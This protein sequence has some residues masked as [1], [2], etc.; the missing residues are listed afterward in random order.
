ME[1]G[2]HVPGKALVVADA[3]SRCNILPTACSDES[4]VEEIESSVVE[5]TRT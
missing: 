2:E 4:K 5:I 3:L 1:C